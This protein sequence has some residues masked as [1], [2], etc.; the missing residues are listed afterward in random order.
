MITEKL[1]IEKLDSFKQFCNKHKAEIDDSFLYPEDLES[2]C[3]SDENPTYIMIEN[4]DIVATASLILD[5]YNKRGKKARFRIF[6]SELNDRKIYA[7]LLSCVLKHTNG[8]DSIFLFIPLT[9]PI[10]SSLIADIGFYI[11]RYSFQ[12]V[13]DITGPKEYN[14][15]DGYEIRPFKLEADAEVWCQI[16]NT[17]FA[18]LKGS[19]T[20]ITVEM[21]KNM[22]TSPDYIE[23][24]LMILYHKKK[25]VGIVRGSDDEYKNSSIFNIGPLVIIPEYQGKGLGRMLLQAALSFAGSLHYKQAILCVNGENENA[26]SLYLSEGFQQVESVVCYKY[27]IK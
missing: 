20:P 23:N 24:G 18:N 7:T 4:G 9:N 2:F 26:K 10:L 15:P 19:E 16:R 22:L 5:D 17:G 3:P 14:V 8:L 25:P 21:V 13:K 1:T 11:E 12:L 27:D 6:Y